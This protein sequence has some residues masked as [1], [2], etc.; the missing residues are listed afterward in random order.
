MFEELWS[1]VQVCLLWF[2]YSYWC[3]SFPAAQHRV[4]QLW[5][6]CVRCKYSGYGPYER[7]EGG[8][9][10]SE[11][12]NL[13]CKQNNCNSY[14][15]FIESKEKLTYENYQRLS[16]QE[17]PQE[18]MPGH[19]PKQI[20]VWKQILRQLMLRK[21]CIWFKWWIYSYY[22]LWFF[23]FFLFS[24]LQVVVTADLVDSVKLGDE[25]TVTGIFEIM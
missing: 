23:V 7:N 9:F 18:V 5:L 17:P 10:G 22:K 16:I 20:E 4:S 15:P 11:K 21:H 8:S 25:V 6:Q 19:V 12:F 13:I 24:F 1:G 3:Y 14:G 2:F